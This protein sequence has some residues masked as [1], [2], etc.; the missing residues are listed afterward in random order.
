MLDPATPAENPTA[1]RR[2]GFLLLG[3]CFAIGAAAGAVVLA[4]LFKPSFHAPEELQAF[5][6]VPVL[7][8]IPFIAIGRDRQRH[9][10]SMARMAVGLAI[11]VFVSYH[12]ANGNDQLAWLLTRNAAP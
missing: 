1:P 11:V 5:T 3:V 9:W 10:H 2:I 8:S 6:T 12:L 7:A 4:E